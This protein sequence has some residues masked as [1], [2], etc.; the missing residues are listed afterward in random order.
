MSQQLIRQSILS[1][2][3]NREKPRIWIEGKYLEKAGFNK[4]TKININWMSDKIIIT[5]Q[6]DGNRIVSGKKYPIIDMNTEKI[7]E[8]FVSDK[9]KVD[10]CYGIITITK[11]KR[12]NKI[13]NLLSDHSAGCVFSGGGLLDEAVNQSGY[14]IKWSVEANPKY[15]DIWQNNHKG[16]MFNGDIA[17]FDYSELEQVQLLVAGI[18]CEPFSQVRQN[19]EEVSEN[20]DLTMFFLMIVE[21]VN[22]QKIILEEVPAYLKSE[23]GM[24]CIMSLKRMGYKVEH[25]LMS[26][27]EY[28]QLTTRKRAVI[29]ASLTDDPK[30]PEAFET[31]RS[32]S[33]VLQDV[34]DPECEWFNRETKGWVFDHWEN[35]KAKGNNFQSQVI[36]KDSKSV[37]AIT[38][39]YFAQQAGN[40]VVGHPLSNE[41]FR[42]LTLTEVK[43]I[44]GLPDSYDL[45]DT[46]TF[47]GEVMGQGVLVDLFKQVILVN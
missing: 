12:E 20:L 34:N 9:V 39:R 2:G 8:I 17:D 45:G 15:A 6:L 4:G 29:V 30:F 46:K 21:H 18:P 43:R 11:T 35:Q 14:N 25:K 10:I 23:I 7:K 19:K 44:M 26:G 33:E 47:A 32:M 22:P 40:P 31:N 24:A 41:L 5:T 38:R 36:T 28:G 37:Q 3:E 13:N 42:W 1:I 27:T 16:I